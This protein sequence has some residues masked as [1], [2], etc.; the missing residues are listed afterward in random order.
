MINHKSSKHFTGTIIYESIM[1]TNYTPPL[2]IFTL[3]FCSSQSGR[4]LIEKE[5]ERFAATDIHTYIFLYHSG[6][7]NYCVAV[8]ISICSVVTDNLRGNNRLV[9]N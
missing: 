4:L 1:L 3:R 8:F 6:R 7:L 2:K 9:M 5:R